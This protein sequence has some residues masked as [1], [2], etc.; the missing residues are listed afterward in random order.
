MAAELD[1]PLHRILHV[2]AT[3]PHIRP[4]ARAGTLRLFNR[5][6]VSMVRHEIAKIDAR[7]YRKV[8][9]HAD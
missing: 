4:A 3:R 7:R 9:D 2:L 1:Q 5:I 8:V 6:A